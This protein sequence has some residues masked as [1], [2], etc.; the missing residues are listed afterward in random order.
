MGLRLT[1]GV[2]RRRLLALA[3]SSTGLEAIVPGERV[4][5]LVQAGYLADAGQR[6]AATPAGR[7]RLNAVLDYL[8]PLAA[9]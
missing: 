8:M 2:P 3:G 7:Q 1:E 6:L 4:A 9:A 5:A